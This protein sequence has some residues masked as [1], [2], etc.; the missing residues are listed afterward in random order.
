MN[1]VILVGRLSS[2]PRRTELPSGTE[3]WNLELSC[4]LP[5]GRLVGVPVTCERGVADAWCTGTE[6]VVG[7][8][9]RRR[10]FRAGGVTQSRTEVEVAALVEVTARRPLPVALRR[11]ARSLDPAAI[12]ELRDAA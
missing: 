7:G 12:A 2:E 1:I 10:F 11:V 9:V 5:D 3:R 6:L 8:V 4:P